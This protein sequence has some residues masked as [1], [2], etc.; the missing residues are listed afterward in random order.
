MDIDAARTFLTTHG[1]VLDRRRFEVL[2]N[3]GDPSAVLAAVDGYRNP[4][5]GYGWGL[6]PDLRDVTSQPGGALHAFEAIADA[7]VATPRAVE[8]CD[9]M[10][11]NSLPDGGV[12]FALPV[13]DS[14]GCMPFWAEADHST[15]SLQITAA[16]VSTA[17]RVARFDPAVAAHP[18][19]ERATSYCLTAMAEMS[20]W[21][22]IELRFSLHV[23][24]LLPE[25][26]DLLK[27]LR[28]EI[29]QSG[30]LGVQGGLPEEALRPLD[31][32][33]YPD[34][35][36]RS[37]FSAEVIT[38][39]LERLAAGQQE[40]GGWRVDFQSYSPAAELEW[41]GYQTVWAVGVLAANGAVSLSG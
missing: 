27:Q 36:L 28:A 23:L 3:G 4:D 6:E 39:D 13:R 40:D 20:E 18:W 1:R 35:P 31:F 38:A 11:A 30:V 15:S 7:G 16:V 22:A 12:P 10:A 33:P 5:G 14:A 25:Q 34:R 24:D 2:V 26:A 17:L 19:I 32:T 9:W 41:Q 37:L 21:H 29:P 8:L